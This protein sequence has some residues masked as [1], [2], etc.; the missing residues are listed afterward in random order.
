[1]NWFDKIFEH[2][3]AIRIA[4]SPALLGLIIGGFV[5]G[6][7]DSLLYEL[8][9]GG[10]VLLGIILGILLAVYVKKRGSAVDFM[11]RIMATPELDKKKEPNK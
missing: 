5:Y 9:A 2:L 1:M 6:S 11:S 10:I 4:L 7:N 3:F 8:L